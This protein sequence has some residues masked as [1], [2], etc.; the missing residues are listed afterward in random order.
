MFAVQNWNGPGEE[1]LFEMDSNKRRGAKTDLLFESPPG[2][3]LKSGLQPLDRY[4][5]RQETVS[6]RLEPRCIHHLAQGWEWLGEGPLFKS[7]SKKRSGAKLRLLFK[8]FPWPLLRLGMG[9]LAR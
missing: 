3:L 7:V 9:P 6:S 1:P 4:G 5:T 2:P 8:S